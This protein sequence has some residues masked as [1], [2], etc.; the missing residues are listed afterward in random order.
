[1]PEVCSKYPSTKRNLE[2][3]HQ[4]IAIYT[5]GLDIVGP[6]PRAMENRRCLIIRTDYFTK[7][8]EDEHTSFLLKSET[9][10]ENI[11]K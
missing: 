2:S 9:I 3:S 7:W 5:M 4:P 6:F 10:R 11:K 1:M 8:V